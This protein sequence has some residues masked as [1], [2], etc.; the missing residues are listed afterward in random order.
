MVA[1]GGG[2]GKGN[3]NKVGSCRFGGHGGRLESSSG[4]RHGDE[5]EDGLY[6]PIVWLL[7][8]LQGSSE[9]APGR[10]TMVAL[11][12]LPSSMVERR[13][14]LPSTSG[15][16]GDNQPPGRR[17]NMEALWL[18]CSCLPVLHPKWFRP[19]WRASPMR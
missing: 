2:S 14:L 5:E 17:A 12:Q 6:P 18:C 16:H 13:H 8:L 4:S 15:R 11:R 1:T 7:D 9:A 3:L 10:S 19:W